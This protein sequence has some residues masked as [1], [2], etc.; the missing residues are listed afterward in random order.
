MNTQATSAALA[1]R[2]V[3]AIPAVTPF[4]PRG[5]IDAISALMHG[6]EGGFFQRKLVEL[7]QLIANMPQT[8]DQ[9]DAGDEAVAHLHYFKGSTDCYILEK[10]KEG[11]VLQATGFVILNGDRE[12]AEVGYVSIQEL[13]AS[14]AE[15]DLHFK[16]CTLKAIKKGMF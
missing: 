11:G 14:G 6:A 3:L 5:Q 8:Y 4:M 7:E 10:D 2:A 13:T 9:A 16:P 1:V 12:M 15:L